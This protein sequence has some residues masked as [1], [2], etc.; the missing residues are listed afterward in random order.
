M[1]DMHRY[2]FFSAYLVTDGWW[3]G[4]IELLK[5]PLVLK[6]GSQETEGVLSVFALSYS[7]I[8]LQIEVFQHH[9]ALLCSY[10]VHPLL[11]MTW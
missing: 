9:F 10:V 4:C 5:V 3:L 6:A 8:D 11:V 1:L 7:L 2:E